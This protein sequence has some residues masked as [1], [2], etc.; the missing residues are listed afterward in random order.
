ML[1]QKFFVAAALSIAFL[2]PKAEAQELSNILGAIAG[3]HLG[4]S[5]GDGDGR[6]AARVAGAVLG[7]RYGDRILN[8]SSNSYYAPNG[9]SYAYEARMQA[10]AASRGHY[11]YD[12][13]TQNDYGIR[14]YC[15][16]HMPSKYRLNSGAERSWINGCVANLQQRQTELEQQAY[17]DGLNG[18]AN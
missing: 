7:Y 5:I 14:N 16:S 1:T 15:R 12:S 8:D 3:Y 2:A 6:K 10:E 9:S 18:P 17:E 13:L 11:D 4:N